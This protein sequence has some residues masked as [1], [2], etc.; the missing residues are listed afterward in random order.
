MAISGLMPDLP[1]TILLSA[2][3]VTPRT[4]AP[5]VTDRPRGSRHAFLIL[6]PGCGGVFIGM[7][8]LP[9]VGGVDQFNV[10]GVILFKAE[11][12]APV[13]PHR[14]GPK[15]L[16]VAFQWVQTITGKINSL[17]RV[18]VIEAGKN[19]L[20]HFQKI[21]ANSAA[22]LAFIKLLQTAMFEAPNREYN[23]K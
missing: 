18:G 7:I 5:S 8:S 13:G 21:G 3:R 12:N 14:D 10:K 22:V 20:N 2:C 15:P 17:R 1:F 6:R 23:V 16:Q 19:I 9:S 4:F 11:Y